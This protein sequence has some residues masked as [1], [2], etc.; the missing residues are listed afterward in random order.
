MRK[1]AFHACERAHLKQIVSLS[2]QQQRPNVTRVYLEHPARIHD[3]TLKVIIVYSY[4]CAEKHR[5]DTIWRELEHAL[6]RIAELVPV[7]ISC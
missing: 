2:S 7:A 3:A 5:I 6:Q 1:S 4:T